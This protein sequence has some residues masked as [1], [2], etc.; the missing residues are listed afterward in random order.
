MHGLSSAPNN[1]AGA[2][3]NPAKSLPAIAKAALPAVPSK[4]PV[5]P[6]SL[7]PGEH[8]TTA[9]TVMGGKDHGA[10]EARPLLLA[11]H[12]RARHFENPQGRRG[13]G[14]KS[15]FQAVLRPNGRSGIVAF[16]DE[17]GSVVPPLA[18]PLKTGEPSPRATD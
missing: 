4:P 7:E 1:P 6:D 2:T 14:P 18:F 16:D 12:G 10:G 13:D 11:S 8:P 17:G 9:T 3:G 5:G 15:F